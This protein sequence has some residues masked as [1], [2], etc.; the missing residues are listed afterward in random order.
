MCIFQVIDLNTQLDYFK[1][2]H[3]LL[4]K[5]IGGVEIKDL[6]SK[7][8]NLISI[9]SNDYVVYVTDNSSVFSSYS[10]DQYVD[11]V[12]GN[13]TNVIKVSENYSAEN[14]KAH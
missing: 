14:F 2:L 7:A 6:L 11:I 8:V 5:R 12:I 10:H 4:G 3:K 1:K 13:L 9:G